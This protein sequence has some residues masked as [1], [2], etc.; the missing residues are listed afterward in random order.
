MRLDGDYEGA[1]RAYE[2]C[3]AISHEI[4]DRQR[5]AIMLFDLGY[6][7]QHQGN[8]ERAESLIGQYLTLWR[9]FG[10][11]YFYAIGLAGLAGP[12]SAR[13]DPERAARLLGASEALL[14]AVGVSL[15]CGDQFEVDRYETAV[16]EQLDKAAFEAA[17]AE[18]RAMS[19]EEALTYAL[20]EEAN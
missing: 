1:G 14:E 12:V 11:K 16:R 20:G 4:G 13:G 15:Q 5:E 18:G 9:E 19:L 17:W 10:S 7:A 2:E 6:V 8:Y 3:L